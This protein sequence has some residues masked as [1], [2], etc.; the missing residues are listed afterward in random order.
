MFMTRVSLPII[1]RDHAVQLYFQLQQFQLLS[2]VLIFMGSIKVD[3]I[4]IPVR[5]RGEEL[6]IVTDVQDSY[7][8]DKLVLAG[9]ETTYQSINGRSIPS[10]PVPPLPG[11]VPQVDQMQFRRFGHI[12]NT[13]SESA[14]MNTD[15]SGDAALRDRTPEKLDPSPGPLE[16]SPPETNQHGPSLGMPARAVLSHPSADSTSAPATIRPEGQA[17]DRAADAASEEKLVTSDTSNRKGGQAYSGRN[18]QVYAECLI[19][20]IPISRI[21]TNLPNSGP[22]AIDFLSRRG[23]IH[24][25]FS[26]KTDGKTGRRAYLPPART[27]TLTFE[28]PV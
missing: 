22:R 27:H 1:A 23:N 14:L 21:S 24:N 15:F 5:K 19:H 25:S 6:P 28:N 2:G 17:I 11:E 10:A 9:A 3:P 8:P 26:Q 18:F 16:A 7:S 20:R 13:A 4:E 12:Q